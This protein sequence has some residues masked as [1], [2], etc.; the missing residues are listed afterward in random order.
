M[1]FLCFFVDNAFLPSFRHV[2]V[3]LRGEEKRVAAVRK[4]IIIRTFAA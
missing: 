3:M 1:I 4:L 2:I